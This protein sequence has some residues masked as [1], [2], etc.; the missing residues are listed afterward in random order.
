MWKVNLTPI[1]Y[2]GWDPKWIL[3]L[4]PWI[5]R[6]LSSGF[7]NFLKQ[8]Q[9]WCVVLRKDTQILISL[10]C[11]DTIASQTKFSL[12]SFFCSDN[13]I[14]MFIKSRVRSRRMI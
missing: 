7:L 5:A 3:Y 10:F 14:T 12:L 1:F 6:F 11:F 4:V 13:R 9:R 8:V 2:T